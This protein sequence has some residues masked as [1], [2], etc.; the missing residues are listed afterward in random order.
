MINKIL[1]YIMSV[2]DKIPMGGYRHLICG[3]LAVGVLAGAKFGVVSPEI[4]DSAISV[5]VP[6][7][8]YYVGTHRPK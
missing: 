8:F 2:L 6:L 5:L 3:G 7:M 4:S 1:P